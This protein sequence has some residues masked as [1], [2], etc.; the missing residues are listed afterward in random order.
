M[1]SC[2]KVPSHNSANSRVHPNHLDE[3]TKASGEPAYQ[4]PKP[5]GG[6]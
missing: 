1:H 3:G 4:E 6:D 2:H 5:R